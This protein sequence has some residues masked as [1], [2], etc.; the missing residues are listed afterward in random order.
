M[1]ITKNK[2]LLISII[3]IILIIVGFLFWQGL[4]SSV[5]NKENQIPSPPEKTLQVQSFEGK[6]NK[7][8]DGAIYDDYFVNT[9]G[10]EY[11]I[12]GISQ[13]TEQQIEGF[14]DSGKT[15]IIKGTLYEGVADYGGR[16]IVV[17]EI[18]E[19]EN[20]ESGIA[21]PAS[22]FCDKQGG[23]LTMRD[24]DR[25]QIGICVFKDNKECE[26]WAYF[27]GECAPESGNAALKNCDAFR[28]MAAC[29]QIY[30]PVCAR[31]IR[32]NG[33]P[34]WQAFPNDCMACVSDKTIIGYKDG[35]CE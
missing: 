9:T 21:N 10:E 3:V 28:G 19:K 26:E 35:D 4:G 17:E 25:G 24:T 7:T 6:I 11:G 2:I 23:I 18:D 27:R 34:A 14:R 8:P 20:T 31:I 29:T 33:D 1:D 30:R 5:F 12:K 16:Q 32:E 15:V 22:V 13:A